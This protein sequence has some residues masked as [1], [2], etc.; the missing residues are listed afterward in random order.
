MAK[1]K[2]TFAIMMFLLASCSDFARKELSMPKEIVSNDPPTKN[3]LSFNSKADFLA[4]ISALKEKNAV[5]LRSVQL[6][7]EIPDGFET[8]AE[9]RARIYP[10]TRANDDGATSPYEDVDGDKPHNA[11]YSDLEEMTHDEFNLFR[12][13]ELVVEQELQMLMDTTLTI[14]ITDTIYIVTE[15]GT[16]ASH[17]NNTEYLLQTISS[18]REIAEELPNIHSA[19]LVSESPT[20]NPQR[21][22]IDSEKVLTPREQIRAEATSSLPVLDRGE[23]HIFTNDV[24]Y[25]NTFGGTN[26]RFDSGWQTPVPPI[27]PNTSTDLFTYPEFHKPYNVVTEKWE[28]KTILGEIWSSVV[29]KNI[30]KTN[31]F[32]KNNR[33]ALNIYDVNYGFFTNSGIQLKFQKRKRFL[34]IPYWVNQNAQKMVLGFNY[35]KGTYKQTLPGSIDPKA[36]PLPGEEWKEFTTNFKSVNAKFIHRLYTGVN[37]FKNW[38]DAL[39]VILPKYEIF[40]FPVVNPADVSKFLY[41][42]PDKEVAKLLNGAAEKYIF[43]PYGEYNYHVLAKPRIAYISYGENPKMEFNTK[44]YIMGVN[45]YS[46]IP[47]KKLTL[48][49][50]AGFTFFY[51]GGNFSFRPFLP[52]K[53]KLESFDLFGAV[54]Y[55]NQWKGVRMLEQ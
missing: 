22:Q 14:Q 25:I 46:N 41:E 37:I 29:G 13:E 50:S 43:K 48:N 21:E 8:I 3:Y 12:A 34:G 1:L 19:I 30:Q 27:N 6:N 17:V 33:V 47:V 2:I 38:S 45:E 28:N 20:S 51:G 31:E 5:N 4:A 11:E 53:F 18:V 54:Y 42:L 36:R 40:G 23:E 7:V 15:V 52:S 49:F 26:N 10:S 9:L 32:D 35:L 39:T 16:F 24:K 55:N 44:A